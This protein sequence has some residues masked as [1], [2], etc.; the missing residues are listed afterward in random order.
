MKLHSLWFA[1]SLFLLTLNNAFAEQKTSS[2]TPS[3]IVP[4]WQLTM[5]NGE[6]IN[7]QMFEGKPVILHFWATWCPYCKRLQPKLVELVEKHPNVILVGISF[8]EDSDATPQDVLEERGYT[9]KTAVNGEKVAQ[10]YG[11]AGT[12]TTFFIKPNG[13]AIFK[14]VNSDINDPR[15]L[16]ATQVIA[17]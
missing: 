14:Y 12:P 2:N 5:Q 15:L 6:P 10:Q 13:E 16:K 3:N 1:A 4:D 9:F 7:W 8:N 11:V 17:E